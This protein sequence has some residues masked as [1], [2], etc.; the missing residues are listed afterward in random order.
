MKEVLCI[1]NLN[2]MTKY[3]ILK[4]VHELCGISHLEINICKCPSQNGVE[5]VRQIHIYILLFIFL[6]NFIHIFI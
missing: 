3:L 6:I 1:K 2:C 4:L 5:E